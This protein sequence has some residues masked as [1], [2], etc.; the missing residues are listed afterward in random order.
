MSGTKPIYFAGCGKLISPDLPVVDAS[1]GWYCSGG[2]EFPYLDGG[3]SLAFGGGWT[4]LEA[5]G[6]TFPDANSEVEGTSS[7]YSPDRFGL[8][9]SSFKRGNFQLT[10]DGRIWG[11]S[12]T[13]SQIGIDY[14]WIDFTGSGGNPYGKQ[15]SGDSSSYKALTLSKK[16]GVGFEL[17]PTNNLYI[18]PE[19]GLMTSATHL[20]ADKKDYQ[21]WNFSPYGLHLYFGATVGIGEMGADPKSETLSD[22]DYAIYFSKQGHG[23][24]IDYLNQRDFQGPQAGGQNFL[25]DSIGG[26]DSGGASSFSGGTTWLIPPLKSISTAMAADLFFGTDGGA[27]EPVRMFVRSSSGMKK[28]IATAEGVKGAGYFAL[29]TKDD[30]TGTSLLSPGISSANNLITIFAYSQGWLD[31]KQIYILPFLLGGLEMLVPIVMDD[32]TKDQTG[33][34]PFT[35]NGASKTQGSISDALLSAGTTTSSSWARNPEVGG[36]EDKFI[37]ETSLS[38]SPHDTYS[39]SYGSG[40]TATLHIRKGLL[41]SPM[42]LEV[43]ITNP[44]LMATNLGKFGTNYAAE[45]DKETPYQGTLTPSF[46]T[47]TLGVET[48]LSLGNDWAFLAGIGGSFVNETAADGASGGVG[49]SANLALA[50]KKFFIGAKAMTFKTKADE[51]YLLNFPNIGLFW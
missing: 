18:T 30:G 6:K 35:D 9:L 17:W 24:L 7:S 4:H 16:T 38:Y 40:T 25:D 51:G 49:L 34:E 37:D 2:V 11:A 42:Y 29:G 39:G 23:F 5:E 26:G 43:G 1:S 44:A 3:T 12:R 36:K 31:K 13:I 15:F 14:G 32:P 28:G 22:T 8:Q 33:T 21:E 48:K 50:Y 46:I 45:F 27:T 10:K 41:D 19:F 47:S 20:L